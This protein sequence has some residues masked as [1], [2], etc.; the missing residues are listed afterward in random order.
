MLSN[1]SREV[2]I[3]CDSIPSALRVQRH[4]SL[5]ALAARRLLLQSLFP[6]SFP[7]GFCPR[8]YFF[9]VKAFY[10]APYSISLQ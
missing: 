8:L 3:A 2:Q 6:V 1:A 7:K 5:P 10:L 9:D 4:H